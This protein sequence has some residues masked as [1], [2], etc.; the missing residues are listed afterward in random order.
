DV[1]NRNEQEEEERT[2]HATERGENVFRESVDDLSKSAVHPNR[3]E[4]LGARDVRAMAMRAKLPRDPDV[5]DDR[6]AHDLVS[7]DVLERRAPHENAG[8]AA[9]A[10]VRARGVVAQPRRQKHD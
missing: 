9:D 4:L 6:V 7:A 5:V 2:A 8:T 10:E 3:D 1:K